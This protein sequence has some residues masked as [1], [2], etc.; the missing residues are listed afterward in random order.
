MPVL[1]HAPVFV[2]AELDQHASLDPVRVTADCVFSKARGRAGGIRAGCGAWLN[3]LRMDH[4]DGNRDSRDPLAGRA[5]GHLRLLFQKELDSTRRSHTSWSLHLRRESDVRHAVI[6]TPTSS[7]KKLMPDAPAC[8]A[9]CRA[10]SSAG[11]V[12]QIKQLSVMLAKRML[13]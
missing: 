7:E 2:A 6:C 1:F 12:S 4:A 8:K 10:V 3:E 11:M 5:T 13:P 9:C